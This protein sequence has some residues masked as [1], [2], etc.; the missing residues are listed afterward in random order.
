M[1]GVVRHYVRNDHLGLLIPYEF[2][3]VQH[4][5]EPDFLVK[6]AN[7]LTVVLEVKGYE[8]HRVGAKHEAA[9]RWVQT[10]NNWVC[11]NED[12]YGLGYWYFHVNYNPQTLES[13]LL[14]LV[15]GD[16]PVSP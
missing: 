15:K 12:W 2:Y 1:R 5:Y 6:L 13:E 8:D 11:A 9:K 14:Y 3:G 16:Q 4:N 10:V 7:G